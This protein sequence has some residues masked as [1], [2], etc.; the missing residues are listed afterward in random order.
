[1]T[2][3]RYLGAFEVEIAKY[4]LRRVRSDLQEALR[5]LE[6]TIQAERIYFGEAIARSHEEL[7]DKLQRGDI[8]GV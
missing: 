5:L 2:N 1:L 6:L 7:Y 4:K 8:S 3:S